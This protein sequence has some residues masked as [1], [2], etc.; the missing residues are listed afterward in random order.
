MRLRLLYD[1]QYEA[2]SKVTSLLEPIRTNQ[3]SMQSNVRQ[4]LL[5]LLHASPL[6]ASRLQTRDNPD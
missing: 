3:Q 4:S 2:V 6:D 1:E 5:K